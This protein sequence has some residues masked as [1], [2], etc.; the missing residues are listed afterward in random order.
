MRSGSRLCLCRI[1]LE[2]ACVW[3][4]FVLEMRLMVMFEV[5]VDELVGFFSELSYIVDR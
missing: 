1:L 4:T 2:D 5:L 3:V